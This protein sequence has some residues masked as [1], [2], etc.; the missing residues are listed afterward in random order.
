MQSRFGAMKPSGEAED[1]AG[2]AVED[3]VDVGLL[4]MPQ[5][6][7]LI[8]CI[9]RQAAHFIV[10][11]I[12]IISNCYRLDRFVL[13]QVAIE[14]AAEQLLQQNFNCRLTHF[15]TSRPTSSSFVAIVDGKANVVFVLRSSELWSSASSAARFANKFMLISCI[16]RS[17]QVANCFNNSPRPRLP[18]CKSI[19]IFSPSREFHGCYKE[20]AS[21]TAYPTSCPP[22]CRPVIL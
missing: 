22:V 20:N 18:S 2:V 12:I 1:A 6:W 16:L 4:R 15:P 7:H 10:I 19:N 21:L 13:W 3:V 11:D 8:K 9:C 5:S 14:T 17:G